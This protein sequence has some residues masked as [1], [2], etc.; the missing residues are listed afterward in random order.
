MKGKFQFII[1]LTFD[2]INLLNLP[3]DQSDEDRHEYEIIELMVQVMSVEVI[4]HSQYG[5]F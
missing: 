3:D 4:S 2:K 1:C 5:D